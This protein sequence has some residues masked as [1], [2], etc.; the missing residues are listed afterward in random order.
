MRDVQL[1]C[2]RG[3]WVGAG[4]R[5]GRRAETEKKLIGRKV[6]RVTVK[7][8]LLINQAIVR[9]F[10]ILSE[11]FGIIWF[12]RHQFWCIKMQHFEM[13]MSPI[14]ILLTFWSQKYKLDFFS[15]WEAKG[16]RGG[17]CQEKGFLPL[18]FVWPTPLPRPNQRPSWKQFCS[19]HEAPQFSEGF[20]FFNWLGG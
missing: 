8:T 2:Q 16:G 19:S 1:P 5:R 4:H 3:G 17:F 11:N 10:S 7:S 15:L 13:S 20:F 12:C 18:G 9:I 14:H 6:F